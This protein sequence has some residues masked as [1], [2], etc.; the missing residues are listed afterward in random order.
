MKSYTWIRD[1][2]WFKLEKK[3]RAIPVKAL[4]VSGG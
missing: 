1:E 4:R 3:S 2:A